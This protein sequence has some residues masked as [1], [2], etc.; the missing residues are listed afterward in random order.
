MYAPNEDNPKFFT[1]IFSKSEKYEGYRIIAGDF[2]LARNPELDRS[3]KSILNPKATEVVRSYFENNHIDDVWQISNPK[4]KHFPWKR[5]KPVMVASRLD[6]I[7]TDAAITPWFSS[8]NMKI[9][10]KT[11]HLMVEG[12]VD[13]NKIGR[14]PGL[15]KLNTQ[16]LHSIE[17]VEFLNKKLQDQKVQKEYLELDP[18]QKWEHLKLTIIYYA[19]TFSRR[20]VAEKNMVKSQLEEQITNLINKQEKSEIDIEMLER[21]EQDLQEINS[22]KA[23]GAIF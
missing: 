7:A 22:K 23:Q 20:V 11:D 17:F 4:R 16:H 13:V 12:K 3:T 5:L 18:G 10:H 6:Y 21:S 15:W 19:Q 1:D 9:G 8:I 14:G 2:N